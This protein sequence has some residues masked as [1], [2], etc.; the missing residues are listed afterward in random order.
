MDISDLTGTHV[1]TSAAVDCVMAG[2]GENQVA[3]CNSVKHSDRIL[4]PLCW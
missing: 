2:T 4:V 3:K 1:L